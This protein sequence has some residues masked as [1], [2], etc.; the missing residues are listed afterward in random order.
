MKLNLRIASLLVVIG[1]FGFSSAVLAQKA[2]K[3]NLVK[4]KSIKVS[5]KTFGSINSGKS[6]AAFRA[7]KSGN[8]LLAAEN[9]SIY[10]VEGF[11]SAYVVM[12][13]TKTKITNFQPFEIKRFEVGEGT[14][15]TL[16]CQC[17]SKNDDCMI[18]ERDD[19][20]YYCVSDKAACICEFS[21][22]TTVESIR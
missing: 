17:N 15:I 11:N 5:A 18:K 4:V 13:S 3:Y 14:I 2:E 20:T 19:G 21:A 7:K 8:T 10:K 1:I 9:Y 6:K 16:I 12:K 22:L